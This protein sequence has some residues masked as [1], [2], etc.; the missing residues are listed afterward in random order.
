MVAVNK[1]DWYLNE[2][3]EKQLIIKGIT[4]IVYS[5][6]LTSAQ[7]L[8]DI[9]NPTDGIVV[10][11]MPVDDIPLEMFRKTLRTK[12]FDVLDAVGFML[13]DIKTSPTY[14]VYE[15][16]YRTSDLTLAFDLFMVKSFNQKIIKM[17]QDEGDCPS[18]A[19]MG[20]CVDKAVINMAKAQRVRT[21]CFYGG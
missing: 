19:Y 17:T 13:P 7:A 2:E 15:Q 18:L 3:E 4:S 11:G 14:S 9:I 10:I 16:L 12:M 20:K 1:V 5:D 8:Y 21:L 6:T